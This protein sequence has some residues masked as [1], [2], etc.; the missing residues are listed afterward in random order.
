[1][2]Y[3]L[4]PGVLFVPSFLNLSR[5]P[6][7]HGYAPEDRDSAASWLTNFEPHTPVHRLEDIFG[8]MQAA[9]SCHD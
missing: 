1:L 7:M 9:A 3:L 6:G 5:V 4:K 2:F 8:V